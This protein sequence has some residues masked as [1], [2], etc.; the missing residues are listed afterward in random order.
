MLVAPWTT[1]AGQQ[2]FYRQI[3]QADERFTD[4]IEP[5]YGSIDEPTHI[6]WGREDTWIPPERA[7]RLQLL[8]PGSSLAFI[9]AAGHLIQLDAPVAL[10]AELTRWTEQ[11]R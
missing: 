7:V 10:A 8:I 9:E 4:E 2:A 3:A 6:I 1:D 11:V 5:Q